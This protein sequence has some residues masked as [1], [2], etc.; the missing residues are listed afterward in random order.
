[1]D[2]K[3]DVFDLDELAAEPLV[4]KL[5]DKPYTINVTV[6]TMMA[7]DKAQREGDDQFALASIIMA[8]AG[9]PQEM[10]KALSIQQALKLTELITERFFPGEAT[11]T[12]SPSR[13]PTPSPPS[14][15]TSVEATD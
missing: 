1:M 14:S 13:G 6:E 4:V 3:Q 2:E 7:V 10:F 11:E 5:K 12:E 15:D 8:E 9:L